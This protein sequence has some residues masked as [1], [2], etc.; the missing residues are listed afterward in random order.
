MKKKKKKKQKNK[1][2]KKT[3]KKQ[4]RACACVCVCCPHLAQKLVISCT[5]SFSSAVKSSGNDAF[6]VWHCAS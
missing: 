2:Q 3:M 4:D 5:N 1:K 6:G